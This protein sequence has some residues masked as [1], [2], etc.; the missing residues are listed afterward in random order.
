MC[1]PLK[2]GQF[3]GAAD[4]RRSENE[5]TGELNSIRIYPRSSA[6]IRGFILF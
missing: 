4:E 5:L 3:N 6:S 1:N 2:L